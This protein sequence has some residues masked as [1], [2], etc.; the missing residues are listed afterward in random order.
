MC[1]VII[2][3]EMVQNYQS[4]VRVYKYPFELVMRVSTNIINQS[5]FIN[6]FTFF[7]TWKICSVVNVNELFRFL[8]S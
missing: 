3:V 7:V 1:E 4:P 5:V 2:N 6:L 8:L